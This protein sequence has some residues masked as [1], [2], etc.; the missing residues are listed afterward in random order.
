MLMLMERAKKREL[1]K[2]QGKVE[3]EYGNYDEGGSEIDN[4][5]V[6]NELKKVKKKMRNLE[7]KEAELFKKAQL[8]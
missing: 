2:M 7:K 1:I 6:D 5:D 3:K 4:C 8:K